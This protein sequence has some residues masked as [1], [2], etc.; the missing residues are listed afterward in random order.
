MNSTFELEYKKLIKSIISFGT[1]EEN[2]TGIHTLVLPNQQLT[3]DCSTGLLPVITAKEVFFNKAYHEYC[4]IFDGNT[5]TEYL[6]KNG[7]NWWDQYATHDGDLGKTYGYQL[8]NFN[9]R[10]DQLKYVMEEIRNN[11]R[12][13]HITFWNPSELDQTSLPCCYTGMTFTLNHKS[14]VLNASLNFRSSDVF[15]GLP[16]DFIFGALMLINIAKFTKKKPGK[17][18]Y[19]LNNAHIYENHLMQA[20]KYLRLPCFKL[21]TFV[22][23][24]KLINYEHGPFIPAPLNN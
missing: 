16:Y 21:P 4:W 13:A 1:I 17:I 3:F 10:F 5:N 23:G 15:L 6:N 19:F 18:V 11:S 8:R 7:I 9:G 12:R 24:D 22:M 2:R 20:N 14:K